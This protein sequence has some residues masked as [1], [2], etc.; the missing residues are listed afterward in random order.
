MIRDI[1]SKL[2]FKLKGY[3]KANWGLPFLLVFVV[4]LAGVAVFLSA[5]LSY[6]SDTLVVYAF[7]AL[8]AGVALQFLSF[9]KPTNHVNR[10]LINESS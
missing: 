10:G 6:L 4:L 5:G 2:L 3:I 9:L 7:Y 8:V 1:S